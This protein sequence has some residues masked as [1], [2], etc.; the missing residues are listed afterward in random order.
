MNIIFFTGT[1]ASKVKIWV[2]QETSSAGSLLPPIDLTS[3][4]GYARKMGHNVKIAELRKISNPIYTALQ[5]IDDFHAN[6]A[7]I[8]LTTT[9][10]MD[11]LKLVSSLAK[12][13]NIKIVAFG[14]HALTYPDEFFTSGGDIIL[15]GD[16]ELSLI[17]M[18]IGEEKGV[19]HKGEIRP[20]PV[21]IENLNDLD[22]SGIDLLNLSDYF[23]PMFKS[24]KF[25]ICLASRGCPYKCNYCLYP[26]LFGKKPRSKTPLALIDEL[27]KMH[28]KNQIKEVYFIDATFNLNIKWLEIFCSEMKIR[29]LPITWSCNVRADNCNITILDKMR[30]A[31]CKRI[32]IGVEDPDLFFESGKELTYNL[33][34]KC[35]QAAKAVGIKTVALLMLFPRP[36]LSNEEYVKK[37]ML[38]LKTLKADAF[39]CNVAIPFPGTELFEKMLESGNL[40]TDNWN[41]FDPHSEYLPFQIDQDLVGIR[42]KIYKQYPLLFPIKA[43]AALLDMSFSSKYQLIKKYFSFFR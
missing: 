16:P 7:V 23:A 30:Q 43:I 34:V 9:S 29:A 27:T 40:S 2:C 13:E 25:F 14:T 18:I 37:T 28:K 22:D 11:D 36:E 8:N 15:V 41:L 42:N 21:Y 35:F 32:F 39:Q 12:K 19:W 5:M 20:E 17:N 33:V 4:A 3:I 24:N 10:A 38:L 26:T 6:I 31:G 1:V